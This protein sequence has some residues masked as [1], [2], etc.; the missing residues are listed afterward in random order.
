V[1]WQAA[2]A[3]PFPFQAS[4]LQ[5]AAVNLTSPFLIHDHPAPGFAAGCMPFSIHMEKFL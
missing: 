1:F 4:A 5:T 2:A 3:Q